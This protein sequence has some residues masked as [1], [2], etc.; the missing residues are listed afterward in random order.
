MSA[1]FERRR[2]YPSRCSRCDGPVHEERVTLVYTIDEFPKIVHG[3]PAGVCQNCGE[4]YIRPE[5]ASRIEELLV[6]DA[7]RSTDSAIRHPELSQLRRV[8][9]QLLVDGQ[10]ARLDQ[11]DGQ[12]HD[13]DGAN[14]LRPGPPGA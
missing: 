7:E 2:A 4:R 12:R 5:V 11:V 6:V 8:R 9:G 3:V 14:C 10:A 13:R 1:N